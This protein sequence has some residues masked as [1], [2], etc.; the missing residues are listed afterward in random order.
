M[1]FTGLKNWGK[2]Y[3]ENLRFPLSASL[4]SVMPLSS[5]FI[6][7]VVWLSSFSIYFFRPERWYVFYCHQGKAIKILPHA[8]LFQVLTHFQNVPERALQSSSELF[9]SVWGWG[10]GWLFAS[11]FSIWCNIWSCCMYDSKLLLYPT[12]P[13]TEHV[14]Y[15]SVS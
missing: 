8:I 9:Q 4:F 3:T 6:A 1:W 15:T 11:F 7:A 10:W 5:D 2:I 14:S 13:N 12:T